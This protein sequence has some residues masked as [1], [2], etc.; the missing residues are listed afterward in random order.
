M[1]NVR[2]FYFIDDVKLDIYYIL[3]RRYHV[4]KNNSSVIFIK[5]TEMNW[6]NE[7]ANGLCVSIFLNN[8]GW[9]LGIIGKLQDYE[10][11]I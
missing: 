4:V 10:S 11:L 8:M 7:Y 5:C 3:K 9:Y 6:K 2:F 1:V